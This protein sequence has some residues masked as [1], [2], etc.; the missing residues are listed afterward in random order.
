VLRSAVSAAPVV[1]PAAGGRFLPPHS[2]L[3]LE[4][5]LPAFPVIAAV[6]AVVA[7]ASRALEDVPIVVIR[8]LVPVVSLLVAPLVAVVPVAA[9]PLAGALER[10]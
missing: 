6:V 10:G 5:E 1:A 3:P 8:A 7:G 2:L 4:S 9:A